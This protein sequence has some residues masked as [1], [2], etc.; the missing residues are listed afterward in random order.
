[1]SHG[2]RGLGRLGRKTPSRRV[3]NA[4]RPRRAGSRPARGQVPVR[5]GTGSWE[6]YCSSERS[7]QAYFF[8]G[9]Q[10]L[11]QQV[12]RRI[13]AASSATFSTLR[14]VRHTAS[15][16]AT[17]WRTISRQS[18][19]SVRPGSSGIEVRSMNSLYEPGAL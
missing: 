18:A 19:L 12:H 7:I 2:C 1:M 8:V 15:L 4:L 13:V 14:A 17:S 9:L 6:D 10:A 11:G 3:G 16:P 5:G